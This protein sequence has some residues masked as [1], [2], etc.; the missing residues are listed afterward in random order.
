MDGRKSHTV[1][2]LIS[3]FAGVLGCVSP[4]NVAQMMNKR[5]PPPMR[6]QIWRDSRRRWEATDTSRDQSIGKK[7]RPNEKWAELFGN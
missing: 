2:R 4:R 5:P 1:W 3:S 6:S 7:K